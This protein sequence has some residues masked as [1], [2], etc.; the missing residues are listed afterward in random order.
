MFYPSFVCIGDSNPPWLEYEGD[1]EEGRGH[2]SEREVEGKTLLAEARVEMLN[3]AEVGVVS[4]L[5]VHG[6][7]MKLP[8]RNHDEIQVWNGKREIVMEG[9]QIRFYCLWQN[10]NL[11]SK[12]N[13][14]SLTFWPGFGRIDKV[15]SKLPGHNLNLMLH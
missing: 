10:C 12:S 6:S 7:Y 11:F 3:Y 4:V 9:F 1:G 2:T 8:A 14:S 13:C 15:I 5:I